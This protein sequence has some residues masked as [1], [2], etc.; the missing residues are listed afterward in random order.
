MSLT[1]DRDCHCLMLTYCR[2]EERYHP[3]FPLANPAAMDPQN[4]HHTAA[5]EPHLLTAICTV[6]SKDD[7]D[8][9]QIH[10]VGRPQ[11]R[12]VATAL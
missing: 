8:W 11:C 3:F 10:E 2:F 5:R 7:K 1:T 12:S 6:A 9:W 4:L